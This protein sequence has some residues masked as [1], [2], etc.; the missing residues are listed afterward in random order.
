MKKQLQITNDFKSILKITKT[1]SVPTFRGLLE[2]DRKY[3]IALFKWEL[4][5]KAYNIVRDKKWKADYL[6]EDQYK[7]Y[8]FCYLKKDNSQP[9]GFAFSYTGYNY[10]FTYAFVGSRQ[11]FQT[12]E[13]VMDSLSKFG[14]I[15]IETRIYN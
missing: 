4:I 6:N 11:F 13:D 14:Q 1:K 2:K 5:V 7:Y 3:H 12:S 9:S 10:S 15:Y 8:P